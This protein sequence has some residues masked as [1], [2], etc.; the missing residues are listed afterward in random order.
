[1]NA[2]L[3]RDKK[4]A[5]LTPMLYSSSPLFKSLE[6]S[7]SKALKI[8]NHSKPVKSPPQILSLL[9]QLLILVLLH[10][11]SPLSL[12]TDQMPNIGA[13]PLIDPILILD[14]PLSHST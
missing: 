8:A 1:M 9:H 12:Y 14:L 4:F 5:K 10:L 2:K 13:H 7:K 3:H 6:T 11:Q